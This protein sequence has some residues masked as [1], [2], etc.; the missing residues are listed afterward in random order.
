MQSV[1]NLF[2]EWGRED[3][4][5]NNAVRPDLQD[6]DIYEISVS[7][8]KELADLLEVTPAELMNELY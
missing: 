5:N 6:Q 1:E 3:L 4:I 8:F 2:N 7:D